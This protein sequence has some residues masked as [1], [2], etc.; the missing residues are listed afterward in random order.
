MSFFKGLFGSPASG[1][2]AAANSAPPA[3]ANPFGQPQQQQ[4]QQPSFNFGPPASSSSSSSS[5]PAQQQPP[6]QASFQFGAPPQQPF[7]MFGAAAAP[8]FP[9]PGP[10]A[11]WELVA[12]DQP[13][14]SPSNPFDDAA[15]AAG[16]AAPSARTYFSM[17]IHG[18][19]LYTFGGFGDTKGRYNDLRSFDLE[20]ERWELI[21]TTGECPKPVYLHSAV[22]FDGKMWVFGGSVGK[23]SNELYS[24]EFSSR[25]WRRI[26]PPNPQAAALVP[27]PRYGHAAVVHGGHML[28]VGGC[29]MNNVYHSDSYIYHFAS[30]Q[31]RKIADIPVDIAYHSLVA[32]EGRVLLTGGYN[33]VRF[34]GQ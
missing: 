1:S 3:A 19:R 7:N 10:A 21:H 34:N 8:A 33:G 5:F 16:S 2:G 15:S 23:D 11:R 9:A 6:Q 26:V 25:V 17:V 22:V 29:R 31:W 13:A 32:H 24:F 20:R 18:G 12:D 27:S 14:L 4:Q 30:N 28:V